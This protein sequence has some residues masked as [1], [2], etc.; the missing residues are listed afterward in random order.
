[1]DHLYFAIQE[2]IELRP[3]RHED[4]EYLRNW[5][6]NAEANRFLRSI[7]YITAGMQEEWFACYLT[8]ESEILFIIE[9]KLLGVPIGSVSLYDIDLSAGTA[10]IGKIMIGDK[11]GHGKGIGRKALVMTMKT[12]FRFLGLTKILGSVHPDNIQ[13]YTNDMRVGFRIVG[14][15]DSVAGGKEHLIEITEEDVLKA[16]KYYP[17]IM[18]FDKAK[19]EEE[20]Y[21]GKE[22]RFSKTVTE[23]DIYKFAEITG[24]YNPI[25]IDVEKAEKSVFGKRVAHGML[26]SSLF[27]TVIGTKMPGNGTVYLEQNNRFIK[28]VY[29]GDTITA[30]V[31]IC[32]IG[33]KNRARLRTDAYNQDGDKVI[34][35]NASV[36]LPV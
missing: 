10:S 1:M 26:I 29:I 19:S 13:A 17:E 36:I 27:S 35:G 7:G 11:R 20:F 30:Y 22:G 23:S 32:A 18:I 34:S 21:I 2:N 8:D 5:R 9:D 16:N 6:N 33:E 28:P 25:H 31:S 4:I 12:G 3:V 15:C 24:D 14:Q